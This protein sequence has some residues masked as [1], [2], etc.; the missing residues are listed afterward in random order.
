MNMET[1]LKKEVIELLTTL[2][3]DAEMALSGEWDCTTRE[4]IE[5]GFGAQ[6]RLI[7]E[8]LDKLQTK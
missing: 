6:I 7:D 8:L 2:K 1:E 3:I 5:D 4:G